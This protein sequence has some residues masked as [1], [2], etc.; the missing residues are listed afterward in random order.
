MTER[1]TH[2]DGRYYGETKKEFRARLR[3]Q[4]TRPVAQRRM[5]AIQFDMD[6]KNFGL[7]EAMRMHGIEE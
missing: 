2:P 7:T 5:L 1:R 4:D 3:G 6:V